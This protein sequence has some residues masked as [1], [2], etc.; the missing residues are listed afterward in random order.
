MTDKSDLPRVDFLPRFTLYLFPYFLH[1]HTPPTMPR[2]HVSNDVDHVP[3]DPKATTI[4]KKAAPTPWEHP[5]YVPIS[6][7]NKLTYGQG[8]L[9]RHIDKESPYDVFS[10]LFTDGILDIMANHTNENAA[11]ALQDPPNDKPHMRLWKP[12]SAKELKAYMAVY[13]WMGLFPASQIKDFWNTDP[14]KGPTHTPITS[15]I[16]LKR[17]EQIERYFHISKPQDLNDTTHQSPFE[18][19]E[20][21][22]EHLRH[23]FKKYWSTGTHLAVDETIQRFMGR[24]K[25][26]VNIPSKPEPEGFK[27]WVLANGGYILDWMFH[28]KGEDAGPIDLDT[29]WTKDQGFSKTQAAVLDLLSQKGI[30]NKRKHIVWLDNLITSARL[31][32]RLKTLGFGG[33]G[34]V[35]TSKT[36]REE[37]EE[38]NGT[39]QQKA[40]KEYNRGL[41]RSL[42]DLKLIHNAQ[43]KWGTLY[44][45]LSEDEEVLELA[46]KD[47][48]VVLFMTTVD[49]AGDTIERLRRRPAATATNARTSRAEFGEAVVKLLPVPVFIN[50]YN[51][52][53]NG[54]DQADQ[55][56]SYYTTQRIHVKNWKPGWHYLLDTTITNAYKA[57]YCTPEKPYGEASQHSSHKKF[58]MRLA[59][60]LFEHSERIAYIPQR[61]KLL[62]ESIQ[63]MSKAEHGQITRLDGGPRNCVVCVNGRN[64]DNF[65]PRV[66]RK[67]L[68]DLAQG[69][70][71]RIIKPL[72]RPDQYPRGQFGCA[73]CG[74]HLCR[75]GD[76][77]NKYIECIE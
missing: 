1:T 13:I 70:V 67:A 54:V 63:H 26:T 50:K 49:Q 51:H 65:N 39:K 20:P 10:L 47:Q 55:L 53:M 57:V 71:R 62:R 52:F 48:N 72:R 41:D 18:K 28:A 36:V 38:K 2:N 60:Q 66:K 24:S 27:I 44:G 77:W 35:R 32:S 7:N 42:S 22:N 16:G 75:R 19:L 74:I 31:L 17:W 34:T 56:R 4:P 5:A 40:K 64:V 46:W 3:I 9:P 69:T 21:L 25:E 76:C 45:V 68:G 29:Y 23:L 58:R 8:K 12:T 61:I 11:K 15:H 73:I 30:S 14:L 59:I 43:L 6:I 37:I 33:A